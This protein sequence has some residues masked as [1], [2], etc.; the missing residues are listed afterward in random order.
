MNLLPFTQEYLNQM[1][2]LKNGT[3]RFKARPVEH[4][5][6]QSAFKS[7]NTKFAGKI[8]G[9]KNSDGYI[10]VA[11]KHKLYYAHR[12]VYKMVHNEEPLIIDHADRS[13]GNNSVSNLRAADHSK[14]GVNS[15]NR[16][17]KNDLPRGVHKTRNGRYVAYLY[18]DCKSLNLG[19]FDSVSQ[20][21]NVRE[22]AAYAYSGPFVRGL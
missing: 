21:T 11:I 13:K 12:I 17:R 18:R 6:T 19:T 16:V 22:A 10:V 4:F 5:K 8:A 2:E 9:C 7:W 1:F 14:N 20:A 15:V 3:L